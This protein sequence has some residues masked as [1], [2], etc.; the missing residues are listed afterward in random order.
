MAHAG[1]LWCYR[2]KLAKEGLLLPGQSRNDPGLQLLRERRSDEDGVA[3]EATSAEQEMQ[4]EMD[5]FPDYAGDS[6][7]YG[8][9]EPPPQSMQPNTPDRDSLDPE[10]RRADLPDLPEDF[11]AREGAV[12]S[13]LSELLNEEW[14][15][16]TFFNAE[17]NAEEMDTG[18]D[19]RNEITEKNLEETTEAVASQQNLTGSKMMDL[20]STEFQ[21]K[22]NPR[23]RYD[24]F[25]KT[26]TPEEEAEK[27][28]GPG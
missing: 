11:P 18:V 21:L 17:E 3:S 8:N 19:N 6:V 13:V 4:D 16:G 5:N 7:G 28:K 9:A 25:L 14:F 1:D 27:M 15:P 23:H 12:P 24:N 2:V 20:N 26:R 10:A 22:F